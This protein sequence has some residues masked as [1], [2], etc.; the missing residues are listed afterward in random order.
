MDW[1]LL[2]LFSFSG[3]PEIVELFV[4]MLKLHAQAQNW[5]KTQITDICLDVSCF[6]WELEITER[7]PTSWLLRFHSLLS[8]PLQLYHFI[9]HLTERGFFK[10]SKNKEHTDVSHPGLM[11]LKPPYSHYLH[12]PTDKEKMLKMH[13]SRLQPSLTKHHRKKGPCHETSMKR[14][15]IW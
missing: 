5:K 11:F 4:L 8:S 1:M 6:F 3:F 2:S 10:C 9:T 7:L 14:N 13:F 12:P 15:R